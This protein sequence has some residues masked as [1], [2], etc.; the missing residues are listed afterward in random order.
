MCEVLRYT[1]ILYSYHIKQIEQ[2]ESSEWI[3]AEPGVALLDSQSGAGLGSAGLAP[4]T[5]AAND[6]LRNS[7]S[8]LG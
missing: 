2:I 6:Y 1:D 4:A 3:A 5:P 7:L 8:T